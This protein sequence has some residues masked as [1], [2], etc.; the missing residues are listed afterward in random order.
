MEKLSVVPTRKKPTLGEVLG[1]F[2]TWRKEKKPGS[3][4]PT[5]LWEAAVEVCEDHSICVVSRTLGLN[6]T[7]LKERCVAARQKAAAQQPCQAHF[8]E[9]SLPAPSSTCVVELGNGSGATMKM[10]FQGQGPHLDPVAMI[11]A[12]WSQGS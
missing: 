5:C 6:Y 4:I 1:R 2:K 11:R 12:F 7:E 9:F 3:R 10:T 8:V